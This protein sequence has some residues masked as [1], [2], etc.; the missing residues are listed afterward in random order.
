MCKHNC[1]ANNGIMILVFGAPRAPLRLEMFLRNSVSWPSTISLGGGEL[2]DKQLVGSHIAVEY[3]FLTVFSLKQFGDASVDIKVFRFGLTMINSTTGNAIW[4]KIV[5]KLC[6]QRCATTEK[7][8]FPANMFKVSVNFW[9]NICLKIVE[10]NKLAQ[11][12]I[13]YCLRWY[14]L[15][16][17]RSKWSVQ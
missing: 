6:L 7:F 17:H 1:D 2:F 14:W 12:P 8:T 9:E 15:S 11:R 4:R 3:C 13:V 5:L 10:S 16:T